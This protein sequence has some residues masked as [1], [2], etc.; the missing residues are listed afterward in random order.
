MNLNST[1]ELIDS[2]LSDGKLNKIKNYPFP[3]FSQ[4]K[5][6]LQQSLINL[7][8]K[9]PHTPPKSPTGKK[10]IYKMNINDFVIYLFK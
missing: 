1:K 10:F 4:Q 5:L 2:L 3:Y 9:S 6:S 8:N 7:A